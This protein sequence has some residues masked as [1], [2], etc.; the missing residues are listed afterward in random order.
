MLGSRD[1]LISIATNTGWAVWGLNPRGDE[2]YVP[3]S[4]L[5]MGTRPFLG[6]KQL[7]CGTDHPPSNARCKWVGAILLYL[8]A[9]IDTP[10]S[11]RCLYNMMVLHIWTFQ[12]CVCDGNLNSSVTLSLLNNAETAPG[13]L[14]TLLE[15]AIHL[16]CLS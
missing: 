16:K 5:K 8:C 15:S 3:C 1:R 10:W 12:D 9:C 11:N 2:F 6:V 7:M 4:L 14:E 13:I